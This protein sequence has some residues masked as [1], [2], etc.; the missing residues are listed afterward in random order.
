MSSVLKM[1]IGVTI[2]AFLYMAA[3]ANECP[4]KW[5]R[6]C[7]GSY[8]VHIHHWLIHVAGLIILMFIPKI[9]DLTVLRG[10]VAGGILHGLTYS[11]WYVVWKRCDA[12]SDITGGR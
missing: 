7:L 8:K 10:I 6:V 12:A 5:N 1:I 3:C 9:R 2:G 11:D 4:V